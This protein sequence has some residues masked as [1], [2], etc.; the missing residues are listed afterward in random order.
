M[1]FIFK[2]DKLFK[3]SLIILL[4]NLAIIL[5][6]KNNKTLNFRENNI[7]NKKKFLIDVDVSHRIGKYGPN[8]FMKSIFEVL[9]YNTT[10]CNFIPYDNILPLNAN[11][12]SDFILLPYPCFIESIYDDWAKSPY[13]KKLI[14]GPLFVPGKWFYFP[15]KKNWNERR[16][17]E[18]MKSTKGIG[19]HSERV[20]AHI[21][22]RSNTSYMIEKYIIVRA[23]TNIK[24]KYIKPF[25]DRKIDILF[26][27]KY[28]DLDYTKF[29]KDLFQHFQNSNIKIEKLKYGNYEKEDMKKLAN[30]TKFIIYFSFF[31][32]G[33]IGLKE[34][35]NFGVYAFTVQKDLAYDK[36]TSLYVPELEEL[37]IE[38]A[39]NIIM[40]KIQ[41]VIQLSP[42]SQVFAKI[43]Q[44]NNKCEKAFDDV[45]NYLLKDVKINKY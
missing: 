19:V 21:S 40:E 37:N 26:F 9:P 38:K 33:A 1:K 44:E 34:I 36:K 25:K 32:T 14:L 23:C 17:T 13:L 28:A 20:R 39:Y 42:N 15:Q 45:C 16:F 6:S 18:I 10:D 4:I 5:L 41:Q 35:Q 29:G 11:N 30:D 7:I 43:N 8:Q 31:D 12:K 27:E 2:N 24:P 3:V 22:E